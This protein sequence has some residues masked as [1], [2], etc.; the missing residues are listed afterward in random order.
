VEELGKAARVCDASYRQ[1][2]KKRLAGLGS[3][4]VTGV[5]RH[6]RLIELLKQL[7]FGDG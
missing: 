5:E 6:D 7:T 3:L 2:R 4:L 1:L